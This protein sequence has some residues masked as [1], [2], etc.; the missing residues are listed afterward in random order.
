VKLAPPHLGWIMVCLGWLLGGAMLASAYL[1]GRHEGNGQAAAVRA[2]ADSV[3]GR[4][5]G[6]TVLPRAPLQRR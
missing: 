1:L 4:C 2:L 3:A 6:A 5:W